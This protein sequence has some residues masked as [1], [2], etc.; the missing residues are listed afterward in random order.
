M[1]ND[2]EP[3]IY[4]IPGLGYTDQIF[5]KLRLDSQRVTRLNW[6]EPRLE[7]SME[8]YATRMSSQMQFDGE[9]VV[10]IGHSFGGIMC[11]E[12]ARQHKVDKIILLSSIQSRKENPLQFRMLKPLGLHRLITKE[13]ILKTF[14]YWG[15][16]HGFVTE[17][18]K[19][20]FPQMVRTYS[21]NYFSW[22]MR[23]LSVW[24]NKAETRTNRLVRIHGKQ[25][26]TFP[27]TLTS[28]IDY[29]IEKGSHIMVYKQADLISKILNKEIADL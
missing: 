11:Q 27:I 7:E 23:E 1:L 22:A 24:E 15:A 26:K 13:F 10:L 2:K 3:I 28:E 8:S 12:I 20:L 29:A 4:L 25:D 6:I 17:E 9:Q 5:E 19:A 18:E 14:K 21:N 16:Q